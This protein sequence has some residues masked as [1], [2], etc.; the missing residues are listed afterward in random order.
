MLL[1]RSIN[2]WIKKEDIQYYTAKLNNNFPSNKKSLEGF[3]NL[4]L[5]N[6]YC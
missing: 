6:D 5:I 4:N 3:N 1:K 2:Q